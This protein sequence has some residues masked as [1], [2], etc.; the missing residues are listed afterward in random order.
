MELQLA[1]GIRRRRC[2]CHSEHHR[3][4]QETITELTNFKAVAIAV[5][6]LFYAEKWNLYV[7]YVL[8]ITLVHMKEC[9]CRHHR[10]VQNLLAG[11]IFDGSAVKSAFAVLRLAENSTRCCNHQD[12][13]VFFK[14]IPHNSQCTPCLNLIPSDCPKNL[15]AH[16]GY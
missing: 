7:V 13:Y 8:K 11:R 5:N 3:Q 12:F 2:D 1:G 16:P 10:K 15:T 14:A 4:E 6:A 9:S